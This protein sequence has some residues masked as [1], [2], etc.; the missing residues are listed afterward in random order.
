MAGCQGIDQVKAWADQGGGHYSP[1]QDDL[2]G[3]DNGFCG[4]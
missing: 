3:C 2:F 4:L 1:D